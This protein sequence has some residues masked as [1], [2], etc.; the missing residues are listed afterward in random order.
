MNFLTEP[1]KEFSLLE[2]M[3]LHKGRYRLL[4][5]HILRMKGSAEYFGFPFDE[6]KFLKALEKN[7]V[8]LDSREKYRV[9]ALADKKGNFSIENMKLAERR[10]E[11]ALISL[12]GQKTDSQ[13]IFL[14]HKTT[15]R[16]IYDTMYRKALEKGLFDLIFLNEKGHVTEGCISNVFIKKNGKFITPSVECG[17]LDGLMRQYILSKNKNVK[18][19]IITPG[20]LRAAEEIYLC[21]SVRGITRVEMVDEVVD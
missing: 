21:N 1:A 5:S 12:A 8:G 2:T 19:D 4:K 9:K 13:N 15:N 20:D 18:E 14:Y 11:K 7:S 16:A 3:L 17:L 6:G 10:G